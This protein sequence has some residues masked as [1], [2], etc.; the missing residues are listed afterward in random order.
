MTERV[1]DVRNVSTTLGGHSIH[2]DLSLSV[3]R[4][5]VI[6]LIGGSGTGSG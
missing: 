2:R 1:I 6:A 3:A 5:E 4:G